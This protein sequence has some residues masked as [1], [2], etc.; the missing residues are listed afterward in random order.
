MLGRTL[1]SLCRMCQTDTIDSLTPRTVKK[2]VKYFEVPDHEEWRISLVAEL[3]QLRKG[4]LSLPGF[5]QDETQEIL[6][7]VC[8]E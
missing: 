5:Q 1:F 2:K 8:A 4:S 7:F 3:L 6:D